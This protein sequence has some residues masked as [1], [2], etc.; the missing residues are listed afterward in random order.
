[1]LTARPTRRP[2][3]EYLPYQFY[4]N[5]IYGDTVGQAY[6]SKSDLNTGL[7]AWQDALVKYG[8]QQG[9]TVNGDP[10]ADYGRRRTPPPRAPRLSVAPMRKEP[11]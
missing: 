1:M 2:G 8:N 4:A 11:Q 10:P 5:S 9:F 6:Q 7:K 3:L